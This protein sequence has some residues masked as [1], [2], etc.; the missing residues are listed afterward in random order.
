MIIGGG[1]VQACLRRTTMAIIT[2]LG[3]IK[4]YR[5]STNSSRKT[6]HWMKA[7][8]HRTHRRAAREAIRTGREVNGKPRL[9]SWDI[10]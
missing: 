6:L 5:C 3:T 8:A 1:N 4:Q 10:A 7:H 9:T 2:K